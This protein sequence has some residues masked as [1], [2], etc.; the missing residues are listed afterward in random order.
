M[1]CGILRVK[2]EVAAVGALGGG[3]VGGGLGDLGGEQDVFGGLGREVEGGEQ[4][5][6]GG[7]GVGSLLVEL[8]QGAEGA[9]LERGRGVWE[10]GCGEQLAACLDRAPRAGQQQAEGNVRGGE[11]RVGGD[12]LP[13]AGLGGE[14][15]GVRTRLGRTLLGSE[16]QA[17]GL[18]G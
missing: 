11:E 7:R 16:F 18:R 5:G 10:L 14:G 8:G 12:G 6:G 17:Q 1:A 3:Q 13:V 15:F 4:F 9:G 2:G